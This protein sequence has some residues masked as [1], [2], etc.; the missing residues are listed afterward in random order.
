ALVVVDGQSVDRV[1]LFASDRGGHH[2]IEAA[3]KEDDRLLGWVGHGAALRSAG[4]AG[5]C[6][7]RGQQEPLCRA[8]P[9]TAN[10]APLMMPW[11]WIWTRPLFSRRIV[12]RP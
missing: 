12:V 1:A 3:R 5:K 11:L 8:S 9:L 2:R 4:P 6:R 7:M 10:G